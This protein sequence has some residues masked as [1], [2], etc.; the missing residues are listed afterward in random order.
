MVNMVTFLNIIRWVSVRIS[1]GGKTVI[2]KA[3]QKYKLYFTFGFSLLQSS[4][5]NVIILILKTVVE[6]FIPKT[7]NCMYSEEVLG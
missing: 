7:F 2:K 4:E 5:L 1:P 3:M 6:E